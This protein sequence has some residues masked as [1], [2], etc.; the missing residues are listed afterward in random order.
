MMHRMS[1]EDG[2]SVFLRAK[3]RGWWFAEE[4]G[5]RYVNSDDFSQ[6]ESFPWHDCAA[7]ELKRLDISSNNVAVQEIRDYLMMRYADR[8]R[9]SPKVFEDVVA[10]VYGDLGWDA[11]A[12]GR[13]GD[14]GIDVVLKRGDKTIGVQV[15]RYNNTIQVEQIRSLIGALVIRGITRPYSSDP[16]TGF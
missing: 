6:R 1:L 11:V 7:G 9:I 4:K 15:K 3:G 16:L 14:G 10:S 5:Y 8:V 2:S 13:S 12:V